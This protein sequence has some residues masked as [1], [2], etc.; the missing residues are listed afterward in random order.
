MSRK[1]V[2]T[3][4]GFGPD[5][6]LLNSNIN[7]LRERPRHSIMFV[8]WDPATIGIETYSQYRCHKSRLGNAW[9]VDA[10]SSECKR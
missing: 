3:E 8:A 9:N 5:V 1:V 6:A 7:L 4:D 2:S 10:G